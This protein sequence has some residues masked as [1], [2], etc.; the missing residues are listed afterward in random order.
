MNSNNLGEADELSE[1]F[2]QLTNDLSYAQTF[3]PDSQTT[4]YL[5]QLSAKIHQRIY[6][7]KKEEGNRFFSFWKEEF[8]TLF[9]KFQPQL[10]TLF[11]FLR[12]Q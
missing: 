4:V 8:P 2:I 3:Y 7:N 10:L 9:A 6:K 11:S 1:L 12:W 5:N